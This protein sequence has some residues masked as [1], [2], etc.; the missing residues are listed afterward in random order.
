MRLHVAVFRRQSVL[1]WAIS[2]ALLLGLVGPLIAVTRAS[3]SLSSWSSLA[4]MPLRRTEAQGAAVGGKL[5]VFGGFSNDL[6][7]ATRRADAYSAANNSWSRLPDLPLALTH[8]AQ[9]VDGETIYLIGGYVGDNPGPSTSRVLK[10]NTRTNSWSNGPTL[11]AARSAG[12]AAIVGRKL[13]FFGGNLRTS[14]TD[15]VDKPDHFVLN[16]DGGT[17]WTRSASVPLV[18]N[19]LGAGVLNGKIYLIG[20]QLNRDE[21]TT[22][23]KRVDIYDPATDRWSRAADMPLGRGHISA[24]VLAVN[25]HILVIG[26]SV[27]GTSGKASAEVLLYDPQS[28]VWSQ[29]R[30]LPAGRKTPVAGYIGGKLIVAGGGTGDPTNT[31]WGATLL[32]DMTDGEAGPHRAYLPL[33]TDGQGDLSAGPAQPASTDAAAD[34]LVEPSAEPSAEPTAPVEPPAPVE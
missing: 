29:L 22:A 32:L 20:G 12:A 16:L 27:N 4:T 21:A 19:H 10:Y 6:Y 25:G 26:G 8:S 18:R 33:L 34:L 14:G 17:S 13:H 5:Y 31:V 24:S 9:A 2:L 1:L 3:G 23:Q 15:E 28:N 30:A 11:P 7:Q